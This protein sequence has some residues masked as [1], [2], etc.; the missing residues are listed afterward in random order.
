[1]VSFSLRLHEVRLIFRW[2]EFFVYVFDISY[3]A[4]SAALS[5]SIDLPLLTKSVSKLRTSS[6]TFNN[7]SH[8]RTTARTRR[9]RDRGRMRI[10][11]ELI[12]KPW[13]EIIRFNVVKT[14][15]DLL[16]NNRNNK[17]ITVLSKHK[18][19]RTTQKCNEILNVQCVRHL[20][21]KSI[22]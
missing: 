11:W 16:N 2:I 8:E 6:T 9:T 14:K 7:K 4:T 1:M 20:Y 15:I 5:A 22:C 18:N 13:T 17:N 12:A 3:V 10:E 21:G 19:R